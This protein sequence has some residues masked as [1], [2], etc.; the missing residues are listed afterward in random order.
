MK[1]CDIPSV[2]TRYE[3]TDSC[4]H[5]IVHLSSCSISQTLSYTYFLLS[6]PFIIFPPSMHLLIS[7]TSPHSPG[8]TSHSRL[9]HLNCFL[10]SLVP[11]HSFALILT[12][13]CPLFY[14]SPLIPLLFLPLQ[15]DFIISFHL[16]FSLPP[17]C[18]NS[19]TSYSLRLSLIF[20]FGS[21]SNTF[22]FYCS[23][24]MFRS[25]YIWD[26]EA[27]KTGVQKTVEPA[28]LYKMPPDIIPWISDRN[29]KTRVCSI[30]SLCSFSFHNITCTLN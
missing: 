3:E 12:P 21:P 25:L 17:A 18:S 29:K 11:L 23:F 5:V 14:N 26:N 15:D 20:V 8:S 6:P 30:F 1:T 27:I 24:L 19:F 22:S 10:P 7:P 28:Y 16:S 2:V 13:F 4:N 9:S